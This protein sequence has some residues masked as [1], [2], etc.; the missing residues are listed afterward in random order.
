VSIRRFRPGNPR[1]LIFLSILLGAAIA[2]LLVIAP[3]DNGSDS[4]NNATTQV[5]STCTIYESGADVR[6]T[7]SGTDAESACT[8]TTQELSG[9]GD[10]WAVGSPPSS[11]SLTEVCA[12]KPP[13]SDASAIVEG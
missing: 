10:Y 11:D 8:K 4:G 2:A 3:W 6:L 7:L 12:L 13:D 5:A 9:N 1:R